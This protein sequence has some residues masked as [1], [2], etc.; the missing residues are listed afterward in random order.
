M[1]KIKITVT[2]LTVTCAIICHKYRT[3]LTITAPPK[4]RVTIQTLSKL[5]SPMLILPHLT[6]HRH[7]TVRGTTGSNEGE[8]MISEPGYEQMGH[9]GAV[10]QT[11]WS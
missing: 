10:S 7:C 8:E 4:I 2:H 1:L 9:C 5:I 11:A 6:K 3:N